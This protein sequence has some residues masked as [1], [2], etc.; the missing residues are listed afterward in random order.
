[1]SALT[2]AGLA[3]KLVSMLYAIIFVCINFCYCL[4]SLQKT[5]LYTTM[6]FQGKS[7]NPPLHKLQFNMNKIILLMAF[8][9][10][11]IGCSSPQ[12]NTWRRKI[13]P[14]VGPW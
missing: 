4:F 13:S 11:V 5:D 10:I 6:T 1:M 9:I 12:E 2:A 7:I 14:F 3:P 8:V